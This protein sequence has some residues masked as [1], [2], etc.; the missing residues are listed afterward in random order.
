MSPLEAVVTRSARPK[1]GASTGKALVVA[2]FADAAFDTSPGG[3]GV[4]TREYDPGRHST[5]RETIDAPLELT[6]RQGTVTSAA[7][8]LAKIVLPTVDAG[9]PPVWVSSRGHEAR[10][11][12]RRHNREVYGPHWFDEPSDV[13]VTNGII[14]FWAVAGGYLAVSAVNAGAWHHMGYLPVT[15]SPLTSARLVSISRDRVVVILTDGAGAVRAEVRRGERMIRLSDAVGLVWR[16]EPESIQRHGITSV[17]GQFGKAAAFADIGLIE[18]TWPVTKTSWAF[19]GWWIPDDD[20]ATQDDSGIWYATDDTPALVSTLFYRDG[21]LEWTQDGDTLTSVPLTFDAGEPVFIALSYT[22]AARRLSVKVDS[23]SI[24]HVTDVVGTGTA[25]DNFASFVLAPMFG[26]LGGYSD[27]Y[28]DTYD[29]TGGVGTW[30]FDNAMVFG[31]GLTAAEAAAL[32]TATTGLGSLPESESRLAWYLHFDDP[33]DS[34]LTPGIVTVGDDR[35][36]Y[37]ALA[38]ATYDEAADHEAQFAAEFEQQ[39]RVR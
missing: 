22:T 34:G 15:A 35:G 24:A 10:A 7:D 38:G 2:P 18:M 20:S 13:I 36:A 31:E 14:R 16:A 29:I 9:D 19:A 6:F 25:E 17:A 1:S 3:D 11:Y 33:A 4:G 8:A 27:I 28:S 30:A 12:D 26:D 32:S 5:A 39:I 21:V 23:G 37:L